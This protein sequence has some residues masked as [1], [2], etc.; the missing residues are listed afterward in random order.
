MRLFDSQKK[1]SYKSYLA[2]AIAILAARSNP[3]IA[4][5][6]ITAA[7]AS[8]TQNLLDYTRSNE[9]EADRIGLEILDKA[10]Y[11]TK[12]FIDF[13]QHFRNLIILVLAQPQLFKNSSNYN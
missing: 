13:F 4:S 12:G 2:L 5:G 6:A 10:G 8:Q 7:S 1:N 9:Q 11:D 3:Q